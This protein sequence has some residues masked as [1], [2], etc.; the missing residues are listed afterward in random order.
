M[1]SCC[2]SKHMPAPAI[3]MRC[4][5]NGWLAKT[6]GGIQ[7][8]VAS[9]SRL[10]GYMHMH[11]YI[12]ISVQSTRATSDQHNMSASISRRRRRRGKPRSESS[13]N[14]LTLPRKT[15]AAEHDHC[16]GTRTVLGAHGFRDDFRRTTTSNGGPMR[17]RRAR[18]FLL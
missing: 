2:K 3:I 8:Q 5:R 17:A 9:M 10:Q 7:R 18:L 11:T 13:G 4:G 1:K 15:M 12:C 16:G 14:P 6:I